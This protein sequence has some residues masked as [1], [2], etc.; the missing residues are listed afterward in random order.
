MYAGKRAQKYSKGDK[1]TVFLSCHIRILEWIYTLQLHECEGT[2]W[3][4]Q[5][6]YL[7]LKWLQRDSNPQPFS[8]QFSQDG[9]MVKWLNFAEW[10][11]VLYELQVFMDWNPTAMAMRDGDK[12]TD[13]IG[14]QCLDASGL[15]RGFS[16]WGRVCKAGRR[17]VLI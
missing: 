6:R 13:L 11:S 5:T 4:K 14:R 15:W 8:Q 2:P 3:S 1:E 10:L 7:T 17:V 16:G 12:Q 9:Q